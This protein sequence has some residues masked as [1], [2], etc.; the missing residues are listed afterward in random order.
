MPDRSVAG[1][2]AAGSSRPVPDDGDDGG[3]P[4]GPPSVDDDRPGDGSE[5]E[6]T[7]AEASDRLV[8]EAE[9]SAGPRSDGSLPE[10]APS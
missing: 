7:D 4:F 6:E 2:A 9:V 5:A 10:R 1:P 8:S 3:E